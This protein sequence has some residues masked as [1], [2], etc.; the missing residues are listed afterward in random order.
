M[1]GEIKDIQCRN[2]G[3][4]FRPNSRKNTHYCTPRCGDHFRNNRK[5]EIRRGKLKNAAI[6]DA[7]KIVRNHRI[8]VTKAELDSKGFK[9][10]LFDKIE[11]FPIASSTAKS[12]LVYYGYYTIVNENGLLQITRF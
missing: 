5:S 1:T 2:C 7:Y 10:E 11:Y 8:S 12:G 4:S 9:G 6:L 3:E